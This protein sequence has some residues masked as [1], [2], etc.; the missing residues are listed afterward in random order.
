MRKSIFLTLLLAAFFVVSANPVDVNTAKSIGTKFLQASTN[1]KSA[2]DLQLVATYNIDRGDAAFYVFNAENG[3]VIVSAD[4]CATPI[5]AYSDEG[6]FNA[7]DVP[8]AMQGYLEGFIERIKYGVSKDVS[9]EQILKRWKL[10]KTTGRMNDK[11]NT[12]VVSPLLTSLWDQNRYYN[13]MCPLAASGGS[14][15]H[16][17]AGCVATAMGQIMYYHKKPV[18]GKGSHSYTHATYGTQS[19]NFGATTY[20]WGNMPDQLTSGSTDDQKNAVATLL[21]HCGV[22]VNM[23]YGTGGSGANSRDVPY[24]LKTYFRYSTEMSE[25]DRNDYDDKV[26]LARVKACL[27]LHRPVY[28]SGKDVANNGKISGHAFVCDGYDDNDLLHMNW[29]WSG[30]KNCY[31]AVDVVHPEGD[32]HYFKYNN[33]AIFNIHPGD[34]GITTTHTVDVAYNNASLGTVSGGGTDIANGAEITIT[35]TAVGD[36]VFCYWSENGGIVSTD[37][38]YKFKVY[39][40]RDI[41][42][43]FMEPNSLTITPSVYESVGGTVSASADYSYG[44]IATIT[45]TPA[46]NYTFC[47]WMNGTEIVSSDNPYSF[48]VTENSN[49]TAR[50][51]P[52]ADVCEII[53]TLD[54]YYKDGWNGN[55]LKVKYENTF[56]DV[57]EPNLYTATIFNRK[58]VDGTQVAL[59][60]TLGLYVDECRFSLKNSNG[61][62]FYDVPSV[63]P[64]TF[65]HSF[66]MNCSA[67]SG[68]VFNGGMSSNKW[69]ESSNWASGT[70]PTSTDITNINSDVTVDENVTVGTLNIFEDK[71]VTINFG[72]TLTVTGTIAQLS[73]SNIVIEDGGQLVNE[74]QGIYGKVKKNVNAYEESVDGWY[75][76]STPADDIAF[77]NVSNLT[78]VAYDVYR[79][80]E[81][82]ATWENC[83]NPEH[84]FNSFES[85]RGYL[86]RRADDSAL[87][88]NGTLTTSYVGYRLSYTTAMGDLKGFHLIG[89]PYAHN[90]YKGANT[91][92]YNYS[93]LE[94]GFYTLQNNGVWLAGAD[95]ST[96]INPCE[97]ILVK[98][99]SFV[100][101]GDW[102]YFVNSTASGASK[103]VGNVIQF[104][105]SNDNFEDVAYAIFKDGDGL[106]K[107]EHRND[108]AQM[109]YIHNNDADYAVADIDDETKEFDLYFKAATV[110]KYN[111]KVNAD[112]D[113]SYLHLI[114]RLTGEDVDLL[115]ETEY[116]FVGSPSDPVERFVIAMANP[117]SLESSENSMFAYQNGDEI[118]ITDEGTLQIFDIM[119]RMISTNNVVKGETIH[120]PAQTGV[121][122]F[123]LLGND[124]KTQKIIIK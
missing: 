97:A 8:P 39:Y 32:A 108:K 76:V 5:L 19:V 54:D 36:N 116:S 75:A 77:A 35:A 17:Y 118:V 112:G 11:R 67:S 12:P 15:G 40:S 71:T 52:E 91:A 57:L 41:E 59:S 16:V 98:A 27:D 94:D 120:K 107:I 53:F 50:F 101:Q 86:Y 60:W 26:W 92:F 47:Y 34:D 23:D 99:K 79:Y 74:T 55:Q 68:C 104:A 13:I 73:G 83:R 4:D 84:P 102:L 90:I 81:S 42:A 51:A 72:V 44:D 37:K 69:S 100:T 7:D 95:N 103:D 20:G 62:V 29:G 9:D 85:G 106:N 105:V 124:I 28:Y 111:L 1:V 61:V 89:N 56:T 18:T 123:Q 49:F 10:V 46:E 6:V 3:F 110:G 64:K 115:T 93:Y 14:G 22:S 43:V 88:F 80:N 21:Y 117:D 78:D 109:L 82:V 45:A 66:T 48:K 63:N 113:F 119:G 121:Y 87:E 38:V 2:D 33:Y 114:D 30:S 65:G 122:I 70:K 24:V 25:G 96:P 31:V 58:V